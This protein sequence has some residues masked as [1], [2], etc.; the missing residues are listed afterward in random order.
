MFERSRPIVFR[1]AKRWDRVRDVS[2]CEP[3]QTMSKSSS[4]ALIDFCACEARSSSL[5]I[6]F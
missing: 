1:S 4:P 6:V 5:A 3:I 2:F